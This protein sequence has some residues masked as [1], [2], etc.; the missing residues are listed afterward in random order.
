MSVC[1]ASSIAAKVFS[2]KTL[3]KTLSRLKAPRAHQAFKNEMAY[4]QTRLAILVSKGA[5]MVDMY[6]RTQLLWDSWLGHKGATNSNDNSS[7]AKNRELSCLGTFHV[8]K[9][10]SETTQ[11]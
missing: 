9:R 8:W 7:N 11:F 1:C 4:S 6:L 5:L 10:S 2:E 3:Q